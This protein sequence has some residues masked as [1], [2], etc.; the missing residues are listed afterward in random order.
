MTHPCLKILIFVGAML[1]ASISDAAD[2]GSTFVREDEVSGGLGFSLGFTKSTPEGFKWFNDYGHQLYKRLWINLQF[3]LVT[4]GGDPVCATNDTSC[5][6]NS[7]PDGF[8]M[9]F[10]GG[11]KVKWLF[12]E[13][14]VQLHWKSG[15][16]SNVIWLPGFQGVAMAFRNGVGVRY[17]VIPML[18]LGIETALSLGP[19]FLKRSGTTLFASYDFSAGAE[20]RF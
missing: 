19:A 1:C 18:G 16:A 8:A 12:S 5:T 17:F 2:R 4:G 15:L 10:V 7:S 9:E 11:V 6:G 20:F 3:N 14:P 13:I